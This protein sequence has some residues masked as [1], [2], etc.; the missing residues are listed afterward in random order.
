MEILQHDILAKSYNVLCDDDQ[1]LIQKSLSGCCFEKDWKKLTTNKIIVPLLR[2][3][4]E[5]SFFTSLYYQVA[6]RN[7]L[8]INGRMEFYIFLSGRQYLY[9]N[10][11]PSV[12]LHHYRSSSIL[13]K[14]VF[15]LDLLDSMH[16][17]DAFGIPLKRI[18]NTQID[19]DHPRSDLYNQVHLVKLTPKADIFE[20]FSPNSLLEYRFLVR[21]CMQSRTAF[22]I[23]FME[24]WFPNCRQD[25]H[26]I[27]FEESRRFGDVSCDDL[28]RL[29]S[30]VSSRPDYFTSTLHVA[31]SSI[32][33]TI[34]EL[35]EARMIVQ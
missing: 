8:H 24:R 33:G 12:N 14:T 32:E 25:L 15:D 21:Q 27:G 31:A 1:D 34:D 26:N 18:Q 3:K 10:A 22:V 35:E 7:G 6:H 11:K 17:K 28:L 13:C 2:S 23:P 19:A 5:A 16:L 29:Y 20:R 4:A 9:L 30:Y